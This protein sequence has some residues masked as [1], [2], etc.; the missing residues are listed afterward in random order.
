MRRIILLFFICAALS[1]LVSCSKEEVDLDIL[2]PSDFT[3]QIKGPD[4]S[5][6]FFSSVY[7]KIGEDNITGIYASTN[8]KNVDDY[9]HLS[10]QIKDVEKLQDGKE[11]E[12]DRVSFGKMF[13]S[14]SYDYAHSYSGKIFLVEN[15]SK[16]VVL[17][18][19][20]VTFILSNDKYV[21]NGDMVCQYSKI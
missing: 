1:S 4:K 5:E 9:L 14:S 12:V 20:N 7:A 11:I 15:N 2:Q 13:S 21:L 16:V 18:L 19:E 10:I 6:F 17:R 3:V 8:G